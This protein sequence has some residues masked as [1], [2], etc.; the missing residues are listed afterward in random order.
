MSYRY[1]DGCRKQTVSI[2]FC[3]LY[4]APCSIAA[5]VGG[6][7]LFTLAIFHRMT[8]HWVM[9]YDFRCH[10][11]DPPM[12][13]FG[14]TRNRYSVAPNRHTCVV[15]VKKV[16]FVGSWN[17]RVIMKIRR[18]TNPDIYVHIFQYQA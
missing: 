6:V 12:T 8:S 14:A 3:T 10:D 9:T 17:A 15:C 1:I 13:S 2:P 11:H 5:S 4:P 18:T 7:V 16:L